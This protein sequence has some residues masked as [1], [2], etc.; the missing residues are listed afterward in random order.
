MQLHLLTLLVWAELSPLLHVQ[1]HTK[2]TS[3]GLLLGSPLLCLMCCGSRRSLSSAGMSTGVEVSILPPATGRIEIPTHRH[4][5]SVTNCGESCDPTPTWGTLLLVPHQCHG[6]CFHLCRIAC[7]LK[8]L[9]CVQNKTGTN[10]KNLGCC[11]HVHKE[12]PD[13]ILP[14]CRCQGIP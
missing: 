9:S 13:G 3:S 11:C 12:Y 5:S 6:F 4:C 1:T 14:L 7:G 10:H 8:H 2:S